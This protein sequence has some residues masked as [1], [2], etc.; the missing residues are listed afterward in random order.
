MVAEMDV[1]FLCAKLG[2]EAEPRAD[3]AKYLATGLSS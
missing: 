3:H 1:A 2:I